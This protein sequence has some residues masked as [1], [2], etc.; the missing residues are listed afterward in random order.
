MLPCIGL[1]NHI[2]V[3]FTDIFYHIYICLQIMLT[4]ALFA[5]KIVR[6]F[7]IPAIMRVSSGTNLFKHTKNYYFKSNESLKYDF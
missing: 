7:E 4:G 5:Q 2:F 6:L 1:K 3:I